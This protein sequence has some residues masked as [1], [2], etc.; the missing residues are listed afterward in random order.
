MGNNGPTADANLA[1]L[2]YQQAATAVMRTEASISLSGTGGR[3][4]QLLAI[5]PAA[6]GGM[7][8]FRE[9]FADSSL[10]GVLDPLQSR[11]ELPGIVVPGVPV[12]V[13]AWIH[14]PEPREATTL[15][16]RFEDAAGNS[17]LVELGVLEFTG[18]QELSGQLVSS[19]GELQAPVR[20]TALILSSPPTRGI[21]GADNSIIIDDLAVTGAAG[22]RT[23][24]EGFEA[25][26][27]TWQSLASSSVANDTVEA[28][29]EETH[30]GARALKVSLA[31]GASNAKRGLFP[32]SD[33]IPIPLAASEQMLGQLGLPE[34]GRAVLLVGDVPVP[35][36]VRSTYRLFPT[37]PSEDGPSAIISRDELNSWLRT[38]AITQRIEMNEIWATFK[39][40]VTGE[41][42][43]EFARLLEETPFRLEGSVDR[44]ALFAEIDQDPL[45]AGTGISRRLAAASSCR[46]R[47]R[48]AP[49]RRRAPSPGIRVMR[50]LG[51][52]R[53]D[54]LYARA[55]VRSGRWHRAGEPLAASWRPHAL[56]STS[57]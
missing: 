15:W 50:A 19:A 28:T 23:V 30:G 40:G 12:S 43:E 20:L 31:Q 33:R 52:P 42:R 35:V 25:A 32:I 38:W 16:A 44:V 22:Q 45:L 9:D 47:C 57:P 54:S 29:S 6:A 41:Q 14:L 51:F 26:T 48:R 39:P 7:L 2:P 1:Q 18:W 56:F 53:T 27:A 49:H 46:R 10:E 34:G 8:W 13:S 3:S 11:G 21:T 17:P 36:E 24:V 5:D 37:L 55:R 4:L